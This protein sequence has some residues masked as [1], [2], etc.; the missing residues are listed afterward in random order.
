MPLVYSIFDAQST[1]CLGSDRDNLLSFQIIPSKAGRY[2]AL[3]RLF[4]PKMGTVRACRLPAQCPDLTLIPD[5]YQKSL[6]KALL[7]Q[8]P[9]K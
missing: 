3:E 1:W 5:Y 6:E 9:V 7:N 2:S 4:Q 8:L